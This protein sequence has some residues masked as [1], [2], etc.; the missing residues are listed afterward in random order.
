[1]ESKIRHNMPFNSTQAQQCRD[2]IEYLAHPSKSDRNVK[3]LS[4]VDLAMTRQVLL[5]INPIER[6]EHHVA[7]AR[8]L[9]DIWSSGNFTGKPR[10]EEL[11]WSFLVRA[12]SEYGRSEEALQLMYD[13]WDDSSYFERIT[14]EDNLLE[15]VVQGLARDG[16]D[17]L[18]VQLLDKA[19]S[20]GIGYTAV[21]QDIVVKHFAEKNN[22][23]ETKKW[24][25]KDIQQKRR[26]PA[27][28]RTVASFAK[29]NGLQDWAIPFFLELGESQPRKQYWDVLLQAILLMGKSLTEVEAMMSHMVD[30]DKPV[31]PDIATINGLLTVAAELNNAELSIQLYTLMNKLGLSADGETALRRMA[32]NLL[33]GNLDDIPADYDQVKYL[34]PWDNDSSAHLYGEFRQLVNEYFIALTKQVPPNFQLIS[35]LLV[36]VEE[37]LLRLEPST[38]AS[39]CIRFL[40]NDQHFDVMDTV[41]MYCFKYSDPER[42]IVQD[43]FVK[44]CVDP[45]TS[46]QRAWDSYQI[47]HQLFP[48]TSF[49][50][51]MQLLSSFFARKR[52]DMACQVFRHMRQ[53]ANKEYHPR[54]STYLECFEGL[55][56][57]P[58]A[59]ALEAVHNMMKMDTTI[60]PDTKLYTALMFAFASCE[61][62]LIA[63]DYWHQITG[64]KQGPSY[65]SLEAIFYTLERRSGGQKQAREI[66]DRIERMDLDIPASVYNAYI[67]AIAGSGVEKEVRNAITKMPA[68]VGCE[69]EGMT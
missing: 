47:L 48:D 60:Q 1:M 49:E 69:P 17:E 59:E 5:K 39:T 9:Y 38:V 3:P 14:Q 23:E 11:Q 53:H 27:V 19:E 13:K 68:V 15:F 36:S 50:R 46:T 28:Y 12:L 7:L 45:G 61:K 6:T 64:S 31:S 18:L 4:S 10:P 8:T 34:Q 42:E 20:S 22:I 58:D 66:W 30:F 37:E 25:T 29:R 2:L 24:F 44:F 51:R 52:S 62:P 57:H 56:K 67:G 40:E 55:A 21:L 33:S 63:I 54:M 26:R 32:L 41:S 65:A 16:C 35:A 43:A